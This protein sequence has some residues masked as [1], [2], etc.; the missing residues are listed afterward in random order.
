LIG[1]RRLTQEYFLRLIYYHAFTHAILRYLMT[2]EMPRRAGW[3]RLLRLVPHG[4]RRGVFSARCQQ[5]WLKGE[6][7]AAGLIEEDGL[8]PLKG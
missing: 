3:G 6:D 8:K 1:A 2:G 4:L 7:R 5:R